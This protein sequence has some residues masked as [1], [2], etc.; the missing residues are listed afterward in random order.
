M[1][2][3]KGSPKRNAEKTF[4]KVQHHFMIKTLRKIGIERMYLNIVKAIYDKPTSNIILNGEK[5]KLF[6]LKLGTRQGCPLSPLLFSIVLEFL[7]SAIRQEEK[8]KE[9]QIG[10]ETVKISL[11]ADDMILYLRDPKNSTQKL[12][13]T[14]N[15]YSKE[16]GYKINL[17]KSLACL[18]TNNE[19]TEKKYMETIPFIIAFPKIK[20]LGVNLTKDVNEFYKEN[21]KLLKRETEEDYRRWKALP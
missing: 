20:Y 14:I 2:H 13:D 18:Y 7:A 4:Y 3:S 8:I 6:P 10:K 16:A 15:S 9:I 5:L 1:G 12:L 21:Y 17:Q 19:Q 11:L